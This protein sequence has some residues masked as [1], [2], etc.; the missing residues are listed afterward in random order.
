VLTLLARAS[1]KK[2]ITSDLEVL[3]P[4]V[5][6][7]KN[8]NKISCAIVGDLEIDAHW[9]ARVEFQLCFPKNMSRRR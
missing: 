8:L 2:E 9:S 4:S 7:Q 1:K 6:A 5:T 3:P